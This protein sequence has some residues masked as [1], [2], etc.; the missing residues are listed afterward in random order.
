MHLNQKPS[1]IVVAMLSA[2]LLINIFVIIYYYRN[3]KNELIQLNPLKWL[4]ILMIAVFCITIVFLYK[5]FSTYRFISPETGYLFFNAIS[6]LYLTLAISTKIEQLN[7]R[8]QAVICIVIP[9]VCAVLMNLNSFAFRLENTVFMVAIGLFCAFLFYLIRLV[10]ALIKVRRNKT[11]EELL[12]EK[13]TIKYRAFVFIAAVI[14]PVAGLMLNNSE[15]FFSSGG[16]GIFGDFSN[17][18]FYIIAV[19]NGILMLINTNNKKSSLVLLYFKIVT[20]IYI[21]YFTIVFIPVIPIGFLALAFHGLGIF[22]FVPITVFFTEVVQIALDIKKLKSKFHSGII[23]AAIFG[24]ISLPTVLATNF[25]IDKI[26]FKHAITYLHATSDS[27]PTINIKRL[28]RTLKHINNIFGTRQ[29]RDIFNRGSNIPIISKF[30]QIVAIEDKLISNDTAEKLTKI[31]LDE[32]VKKSENFNMP[33]NQNIELTNATTTTEFDEKTGTYKTWVDLE[34]RN[35]GSIPMSEYK[36][37]FSIPDGCFIKDYYL[38]VGNEKKSG[39]LADKRAALITYNNIIRT[40]KDPGIIY[41]KSDDVVSLRVYPFAPNQTRKTGFLMVHSQNETLNIQGKEI[42]LVASNAINEPIDMKGISFIPASYKKNLSVVTRQAKYYF[43]IDTSQNS[44][45]MEHIKKVKE[46]SDHNNISD[47]KIYAVSYRALEYDENKVKNAV[48]FNLAFAMELIFKNT[49]S[50]EFPVI[51][52]VTDNMGRAT[53]FEKGKTA[54]LFPESEYYYNL[55]YDLS[56]TPYSFSD[57]IKNNTVKIPLISSALLYKNSVVSNT[58][59]SE[60]VKTGEI[61]EYDDNEYHN[62]FIL[63]QKSLYSSE[64]SLIRDSFRQ[65]IL[66][67]HTA[68]TVLETVAQENALLDLQERFLNGKQLDAPAVMMSE[69]N[70]IIYGVM[71]L[72]FIAYKRREL[73]K[74]H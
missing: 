2:H 20:F 33:Q 59:K 62:A 54:K 36:A 25:Y 9:I 13:M 34:I 39:I 70:L 31:F 12:S 65:K 64:N 29:E 27:M 7:L 58:N 23:I 47:A 18:W 61:S 1:I 11:T 44:P 6:F 15:S 55:G 69:P 74:R 38:Y 17:I 63:Q 57:N 67:K 50:D 32:N 4:L 53:L 5:E 60:T 48:G 8:K 24:V 73:W 41:Y 10:Y 3:R 52:A 22:A 42:K 51:I 72:L 16:N 30:Y 49:K 19:V 46:F 43:L 45:Y 35:N 40:P 37:E 56:L 68:F 71:I 21:I 28:T 14:M 66:T 26:N